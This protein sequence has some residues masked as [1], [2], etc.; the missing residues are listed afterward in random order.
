VLLLQL[1]HAPF[2]TRACIAH[3]V[4]HESVRDQSMGGARTVHVPLGAVDRDVPDHV[5]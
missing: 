4:W 2:L 3:K 5:G 1:D